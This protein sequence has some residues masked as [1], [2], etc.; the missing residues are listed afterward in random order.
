MRPRSRRRRPAPASSSSTRTRGS[1]DLALQG[2]EVLA[3]ASAL[4]IWEGGLV[5]VDAG[6]VLYRFRAE[7]IVVATGATE[8]PLVFPGND[9]V[10]VM[11]PDGVRRLIRDFSIKPG[12][13]AVVLGSD[14][15]TLAI[16]DELRRGRH[17]GAEGHRPARRAPARARRAGWQGSRPPARPRRRALSTAISL[18]ASGGPPARVL[19]ARAGGRARRVRR[20]ARRLRP[21]GASGRRRGGRQRHRR[22]ARASVAP[23]P[24]YRGQGEVLRLRLRGRDHEGHEARDRRGLRLDRARQALHDGDD[25]PLPGQA[26]PPLE[27]PD[28]RAGEPDVRV[29]DRHDDRAAAVGA[30]RARPARRPRP[31]SGAAQLDPLAPRGGGRDDPVGRPVEAPVRLRRAARGR[32]ARGARV[33][34]RH[35]RLDARQAPRRG[36]RGRRAPRAPLPEPL[37]RHEARPDPLRRPHL[38][39]RAD[40]GRRHDRAARRRPLLRHDDLDRRG[41][42]D[43]VVRVVERGL[44]LRGGDR[45]RDRRARR[46][47]PRRAAGARRARS[48]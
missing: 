23:E 10:G 48:A 36:A 39:R 27:H 1:G 43:R 29:G 5:P 18:V 31:H 8:Q 45:E 42:G 33:A 16:A 6:T 46:R 17:R 12:E 9:L 14:D 11:L 34:R 21:D 37:R 38:G 28:L 2:V 3:P 26:L 47:E 35:R 30:G 25:G 32:G 15:E 44:G 19:A 13:R 24:A 40:H 4:G 41:R 20:R 22:G 7:R